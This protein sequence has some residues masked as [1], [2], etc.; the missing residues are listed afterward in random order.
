M[1]ACKQTGIDLRESLGERTDQS[2]PVVRQVRQVPLGVE[3]SHQQADV[4][5]GQFKDQFPAHGRGADQPD[6][7]GRIK[8]RK[9]AP[10]HVFG[11]LRVVGREPLWVP[12][13]NRLLAL[14]QL[15]PF[16]LRQVRGGKRLMDR[17]QLC[18]RIGR[19][20][21]PGHPRPD[22]TRRQ[23]GECQDPGAKR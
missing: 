18:A 17:G 6:R 16:G 11:L 1:R 8:Q 4:F 2:L 23:H 21:A 9:R 12:G 14:E 5:N 13:Q 22:A 10:R 7:Q 20:G 15:A 3:S 19:F